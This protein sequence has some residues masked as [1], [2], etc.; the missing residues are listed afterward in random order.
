MNAEQPLLCVELIK[1]KD[2]QILDHGTG[3]SRPAVVWALQ[4]LVAAGVVYSEK[5]TKGTFYE[6]NLNMNIEAAIKIITEI[7]LKYN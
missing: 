4:R 6:L 2:G 3:L 7:Y 1:T 5:T